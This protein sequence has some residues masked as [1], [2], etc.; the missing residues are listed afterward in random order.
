MAAGTLSFALQKHSQE[1][2]LSDWL[3]SS[4]FWHA[5]M[6]WSA[7]RPSDDAAVYGYNIPGATGRSGAR[8]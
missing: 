4:M 5:G 3:S 8:V 2:L 7:F 1:P 6:V